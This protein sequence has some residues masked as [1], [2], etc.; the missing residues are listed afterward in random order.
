MD[1]PYDEVHELIEDFFELQY[2]WMV[3]LLLVFSA[4]SYD[5]ES[6]LY[7]ARSQLRYRRS[8]GC[9]WAV[10][11]DFEKVSALVSEIIVLDELAKDRVFNQIV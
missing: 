3:L 11:E 1:L 6:L 4:D 8:S 2:L 10:E 7:D 5:L 9:V